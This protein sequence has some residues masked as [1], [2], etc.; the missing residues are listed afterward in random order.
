MVG[1]LQIEILL[2]PNL[3]G[4]ERDAP[5]HSFAAAP[6]TGQPLQSRA[7]QKAGEALPRI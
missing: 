5:D 6:G 1:V 4:C 3:R 7:W 2:T